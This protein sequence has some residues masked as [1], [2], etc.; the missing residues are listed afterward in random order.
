MLPSQLFLDIFFG[1]I[2][3]AFIRQAVVFMRGIFR[4]AY[5][6]ASA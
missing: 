2:F 1:R 3:K 6:E 5:L 4:F